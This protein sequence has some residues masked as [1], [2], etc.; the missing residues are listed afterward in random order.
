VNNLCNQI[1]GAHPPKSCRS[2]EVESLN[3]VH[4]ARLF[5]LPVTNG[6]IITLQ[7]RQSHRIEKSQTSLI[8][9]KKLNGC[10]FG[11]VTHDTIVLNNRTSQPNLD[12][13]NTA[14]SHTSEGHFSASTK[15][16]NDIIS[17]LVLPCLHM[18]RQESEST[19]N[20]IKGILLTG[21]PGTGSII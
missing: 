20:L 3:I 7:E 4:S 17:K 16:V 12:Q 15:V 19:S 2:L 10:N 9:I 21:S 13:D 8:K 18:S 14:K 5:S 1:L 6:S 11:I